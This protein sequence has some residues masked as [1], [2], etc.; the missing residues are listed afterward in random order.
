VKGQKD[1]R[2]EGAGTEAGSSDKRW[3]LVDDSSLVS[4]WSN[5]GRSTADGRSSDSFPDIKLAAAACEGDAV[6]SASE[7]LRFW[8]EAAAVSVS[9][10]TA[11][12][13]GSPAVSE[14]PTV[15]ESSDRAVLGDGELGGRRAR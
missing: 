5:P 14:E 6:S 9:M 3:R 15:I 8:G 11:S 4:S 2:R 13:L 10:S 1:H 7:R 12:V